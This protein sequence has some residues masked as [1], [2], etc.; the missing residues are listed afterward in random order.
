MTN[1]NSKI[2][3]LLTGQSFITSQSNNIT[4][5]VERSG[6][7]KKLRFIR[8]YENGSFEVFKVDF[9]FV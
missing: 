4:C 7:G 6:D 2:N 3:N 5:S 1:L 8:T 9:Q